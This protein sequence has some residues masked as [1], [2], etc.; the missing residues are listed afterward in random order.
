MVLPAKY[1]SVKLYENDFAVVSQT[2]GDYQ[3]D[4]KYQ[5]LL[6][7]LGRWVIPLDSLQ[8]VSFAK[9]AIV[10]IDRQGRYGLFDWMG[11]LILPF[12][13]ESLSAVEDKPIIASKKGQYQM[14]RPDGTPLTRFPYD[15]M[16]FAWNEPY[17]VRRGKWWGY[18]NDQGEE[19]IALQY[20]YADNFGNGRIATVLTDSGYCAISGLGNEVKINNED[21]QFPELKVYNE[22]VKPTCNNCVYDVWGRLLLTLEGVK[23]WGTANGLLVFSTDTTASEPLKGVMDLSGKVLCPALYDEINLGNMLHAFRKG[24][25]WGYMDTEGVVQIAPQ[26]DMAGSFNSDRLASVKKDGRHFYINRKGECE[27][28][29]P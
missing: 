18:L 25:L 23:L 16:G 1:Q 15:Y 21:L 11:H 22:K 29:C 7:S 10:A 28:N 14:L 19:V 2:Y 4:I 13:W 24:N 27:K 5:G 20:L 8:L 17:S 26:F 9:E 3:Y 12:E 6:D